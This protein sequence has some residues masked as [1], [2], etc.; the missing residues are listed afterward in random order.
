MPSGVT[1]SSAGVL[2]GTVSSTN[3]LVMPI[4]VKDSASASALTTFTVMVKATAGQLDPNFVIMTGGAMEW[5]KNF[6]YSGLTETDGKTFQGQAASLFTSTAAGGGGG[7]LPVEDAFFD[8]TGYNFISITI[9]P[10]RSGQSWLLTPPEMPF[11]GV[12]DTPVPGAI[13]INLENYCTP[14]IAPNVFSVCKAPLHAGGLNMTVGQIMW[15]FG[16]Q[17][18]IN[19]NGQNAALGNGNQWYIADARLTVN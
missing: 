18:Q 9:A 4:T 13:A 10:T 14:K 17:D 12:N 5:S 2:A 1:L 15:K 11:N 19:A 6:N 7:W 16:L 8:T 3:T